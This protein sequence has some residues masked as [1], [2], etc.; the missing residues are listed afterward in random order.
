MY[1]DHGV[2]GLENTQTKK[3][4]R[5]KDKQKKREKKKVR[6]NDR[7]AAK[8]RS[9]RQHTRERSEQRIDESNKHTHDSSNESGDGA[10]PD[11]KIEC[12]KAEA[13]TS[14]IETKDSLAKEISERGADVLQRVKAARAKRLQK[15]AMKKNFKNAPQDREI[16]GRKTS[17]GSE[18]GG[19]TPDDQTK[20][21]SHK[22]INQHDECKNASAKN[23]D[24]ER[25]HQSAE[26]VDTKIVYQHF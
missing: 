20:E 9:K 14:S 7:T 10:N 11:P 3:R 16:K 13:A 4:K 25:K 12:T 23:D 15:Q 6:H 1:E 19:E 26:K 18:V 2:P 8:K 5:K 24:G 21:I 17:K 22:N